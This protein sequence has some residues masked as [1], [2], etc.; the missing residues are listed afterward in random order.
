MGWVYVIVIPW[1]DC[2]LTVDMGAGKEERS[3]AEVQLGHS[4]GLIHAST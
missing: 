1:S 2:H 4:C 3:D